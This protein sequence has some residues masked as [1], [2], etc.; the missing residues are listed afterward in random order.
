MYQEQ[1]RKQKNNKKNYTISLAQ[2]FS[3]M[4]LDKIEFIRMLYVL[5]SLIS[6]CLVF[7]EVDANVLSR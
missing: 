3:Y 6:F 7:I 5:F 2:Q 1:E 4:A